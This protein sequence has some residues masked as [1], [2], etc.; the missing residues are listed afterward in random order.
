MNFID[1][2]F[3]CAAIVKR[4][5][6]DNKGSFGKLLM[7]CGCYS[8]A[9]AGIM[10]AKAALR[11]G[12][13]LLKTAVPES[14]YPIFASQVLESVYYPLQE[15]PEGTFDKYC[16]PQMLKASEDSSAVLM[17]CGMKN[18]RDTYFW[19]KSF[20]ERCSKPMVFDADALN[21]VSIE[22]ELL[23]RAN[24]PV[25]L[26]P[27]P[28]E[29][30]RLT[31]KTISQIQNSR[32]KT[33]GEFAKE[34]GVYLVLKGSGTVVASPSGEIMQNK[35]GN[36]G[37]ATGGSGDVLAG[38]ISS[39]LAQNPEKPFECACAG[40]YLHGL[41]GDIARDEKGMVSMLPTDIIDCIPKAFL[42]CGF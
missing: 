13:G 24:A 18:N 4:S 20:L 38:M 10:A 14:I 3:A 9:G 37:M 29:M 23:K 34:Y 1:R 33:A 39:L 15:T 11:C 36:P 42:R 21:A 35:T 28:G 22:P 40:V 5:E 30:S 26:T 19:V 41:A 16:T 17:G 31:G 12:V 8:M 25:I 6:D 7:M 32:E 2:E 27:H